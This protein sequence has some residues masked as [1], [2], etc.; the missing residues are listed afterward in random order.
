MEK[1]GGKIAQENLMEKYGYEIGEENNIV[2]KKVAKSE[3]FE[4]LMEKQVAKLKN[5][6]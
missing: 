5:K 2:K 1:Y 4:K 3:N 6:I